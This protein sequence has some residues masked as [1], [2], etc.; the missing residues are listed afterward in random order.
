MVMLEKPPEFKG[1]P[2]KI[3]DIEAFGKYVEKMT[4]YLWSFWKKYLVERGIFPYD[5]FRFLLTPKA[6]ANVTKYI[7]G[8]IDW[9]ALIDK[10]TTTI[11]SKQTEYHF[12]FK[13]EPEGPFGL[14]EKD[15]TVLPG[16]KVREWIGSVIDTWAGI[17]TGYGTLS[18][19]RSE[20]EKLLLEKELKEVKVRFDDNFI[21]VFVLSENPE[22]ALDRALKIVDDFTYTLTLFYGIQQD[23]SV[24]FTSS[25]RFTYEILAGTDQYGRKVPLPTGVWRGGATFYDIKMLKTQIEAS[26]SSLEVLDD[27]KLRKSLEYFYHA[28]FLDSIRMQQLPPLGKSQQQHL[29]LL[30]DIIL[31]LYKS[32]TVTIGDPSKD[33]DYQRRYREYGIDYQFWKEKIDTL[34]EIRNEWDV[35]HYTLTRERLE[36]LNEKNR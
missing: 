14:P 20:E 24:K 1:I 12:T 35:A 26:L 3:T 11:T 33:K 18:Q 31:S 9:N 22:E 32:V 23:E 8:E 6:H 15:V 28:L 16:G 5:L 36:S 10:L 25:V 17:M 21:R 19:Y 13:L 7:Q 2:P 27:L 30:S 29:Y 4:V 34:R